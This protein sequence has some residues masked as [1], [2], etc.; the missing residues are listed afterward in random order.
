VFFVWVGKTPLESPPLSKSEENA[1]MTASSRRYDP[2]ANMTD[3]ASIPGQL[4]AW[5]NAMSG[6]V[7][8]MIDDPTQGVVDKNLNVHSLRNLYVAGS[9]VFSSASISNPTFTIITISSR[10]A[11]YLKKTFGSGSCT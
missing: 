2:P 10:L 8:E 7:D 6:W 3:F 11:D 5:S 1:G 9:S 4:D